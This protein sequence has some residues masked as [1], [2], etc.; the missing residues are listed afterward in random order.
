MH[1]L[2]D[3]DGKWQSWDLRL[4]PGLCDSLAAYQER[5]FSNI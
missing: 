5:K 1:L 2:S 4:N 3:P